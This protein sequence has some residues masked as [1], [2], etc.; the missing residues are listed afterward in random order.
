MTYGRVKRN[1]ISN[2]AARQRKCLSS[3]DI[4]FKNEF[5][6]PI[7]VM[8]TVVLDSELNS[9]A[10]MNNLN[11]FLPLTRVPNCE[12]AQLLIHKYKERPYYGNRIRI[13]KYTQD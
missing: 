9:C 12:M 5:L 13:Y 2:M 8:I 10:Q 1:L 4:K 7:S 6:S 11:H 3:F